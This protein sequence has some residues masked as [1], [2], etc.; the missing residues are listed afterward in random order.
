MVKENAI[1]AFRTS[2]RGQLI[3]TEDAEYDSAR[4][5]Y[6]GMI[7]RYPRMIARCADVAHVINAV[8]FARDQDLLLAI[9][10]GTHN[11]GGLGVC[12]NGLVIDLSRLRGIRVDPNSRTVRIEGGATWG[13]VD[14]ASHAFGLAV[15]SGIVSTTGVAGLTLGGGGGYLTRRYG[16]T[17]DNLIEADVV[18]ADG[19][20]V[21]ASAQEN[22]DLYWALRGGGGNFGV[23]TSFLFRAHPVSTVY[24]GLTLGNLDRA[25]EIM[26]WYREFLPQASEELYGFFGFKGVP[27]SQP[28]T[29]NLQGKRV[30]GVVWC[31]T[32]DLEKAEAAFKPVRAMGSAFELLG[33]MPFPQLQSLFDWL[34]PPGLQW[35]WRGDFVNELSNPAIALHVKHGSDV[36]TLLSLM[37][38]YPVDGAAGR[39]GRND[40]AFSFREAMWSMVIA[41]IDSDPANRE[42]IIAWTKNYWDALHPYSAGGAY[43]NFMMD[44]GEARV[45]ATY[46][47]N[48]EQLAA[49]KRKYDPDNFFR[50]NQNIRP[51]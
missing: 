4:K 12:E 9:R 39:A 2:L 32:G 40:T 44:E 42:R 3:Q 16:L 19:R 26:Q 13:D 15:P 49:I 24:A 35:Y 46:R 50:V 23:V 6:N 28:F 30:C 41:G 17:I 10:A 48:Y 37:H 43:V 34:L 14:H 51:L 36:P 22:E 31:Y 18:L 5:V 29:E 20:L 25:T 21:T 7:D 38:L 27:M 8:N 47:D 33:P 1:T 11:G 45:R